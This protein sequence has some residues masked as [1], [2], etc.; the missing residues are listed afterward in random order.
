VDRTWLE[1]V[2]FLGLDVQLAV[3]ALFAAL[4]AMLRI[5]EGVRQ[6]MSARRPTAAVRGDGAAQRPFP[7][8][9]PA[10]PPEGWRPN[11]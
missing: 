8:P 6:A 7:S 4:E 11:P 5:I 3:V 2:H 1:T 9:A 10:W